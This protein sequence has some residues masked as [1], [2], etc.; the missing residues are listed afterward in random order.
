MRRGIFVTGTS[1]GVG[2]TVVGRALIRALVA[3]GVSVA[4]AKPVES[5]ARRDGQGLVPE[6]AMALLRASGRGEPLDRVCAYAFED[7][8]SPHLAA[9]RAGR[10]I[11]RAV[12]LD[13]LAE[14]ERSADLAVAEGAGGLLVPLGDDLLTADLVAASGYRLLLVAPNELGAINAALLT[15][16]AARAR[17][18]PVIGVVLDRTPP[19]D[20]GNAEAIARHGRARVLGELPDAPTDD[21]DALGGLAATHLDIDA[22]L[23]G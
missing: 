12:L 13:L 19:S 22:L 15:L 18:I 8:V 16:E 4:A 17:G 23:R 1:T 20:L 3:R 10:E 21:D 6:D 7:P 9:A 5:G 11:S 14:R 2:K